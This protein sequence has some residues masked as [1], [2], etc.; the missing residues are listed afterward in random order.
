MDRFKRSQERKSGDKARIG[1]PHRLFGEKSVTKGIMQFETTANTIDLHTALV[2][3]NQLVIFI[4][5]QMI[6]WTSTSDHLMCWSQ[7][8]LAP[9]HDKPLPINGSDQ[10]RMIGPSAAP[11]AASALYAAITAGAAK[12]RRRK[13]EH[14]HITVV[15]RCSFII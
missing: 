12:Q 4:D 1:C 10:Q 14:H 3:G 9:G 5:Q 7:A 6:R 8:G 2:I 15:Q 13:N 11:F